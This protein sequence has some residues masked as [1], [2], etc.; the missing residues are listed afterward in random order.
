MDN[1]YMSTIYCINI[2]PSSNFYS[3]FFVRLF[4]GGVM[5][6]KTSFKSVQIE[7][8]QHIAFSFEIRQIKG[9]IFQN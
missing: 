2:F 6:W 7:Y 3:Q 4:G 9:D 8:D 5:S 1:G